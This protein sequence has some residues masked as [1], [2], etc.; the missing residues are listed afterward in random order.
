MGSLENK[1]IQSDVGIFMHIL[2]YS[3]ILKHKQ[4]YSKAYPEPSLT[5]AYLEF[6]YMQN[7]KDIQ[8][9]GIF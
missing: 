1:A 2:A 4:T 6:W 3:D 8:N 5:L 9:R 7:Q